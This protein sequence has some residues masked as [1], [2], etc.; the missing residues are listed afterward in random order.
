MTTK[1]IW[2]EWRKPQTK[3]E[4]RQYGSTTYQNE[5]TARIFINTQKNKT[6]SD[7][8]QTFWHEIAHVFFHFH[9]RKTKLTKDA[10]EDL[11]RRLERII[12]EVLR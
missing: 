9:E 3:E 1:A 7:G 8:V 6:A 12:Y 11:C 5:N 10:E 4:S 2:V